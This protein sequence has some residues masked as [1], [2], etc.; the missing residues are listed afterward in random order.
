MSAR[1]RR[2]FSRRI[3]SAPRAD[4]GNRARLLFATGFPGP[5][6]YNG[7]RDRKGGRRRDDGLCGQCLCAQRPD[8]LPAAPVHRAAGGSAPAAGALR[9]GCGAG[10]SLR[11]G[12]V[13]AGV[14]VSQ[15]AAGQGRGGG[16]PGGGGLRR[17][18]AAPPA[19]AAV[20]RRVLRHGRVRVG[21]GTAGGRRCADG[22]GRLL[23]RRLRQGAADRRRGRLPG[24]DGGVPGGGPPRP[25]RAPGA[26]PGVPGGADRRPDGPAGHRQRPAGPGDRRGGAGGVPGRSGRRSAASGAAP[27]DTGAAALPAGPAGT[28]GS[29]GAPAAV[30]ARALPGGGCTGGAA[31]GSAQRLDGDRRR[32]APGAD[33]GIFP[34]GPGAGICRPVGRR[35]RQKESGT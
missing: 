27:S 28:G 4:P 35:D 19:D 14:R 32:A 1:I 34:H 10:R 11:R 20:F 21:P 22:P 23:Y 31:A 9:V 30:A 25:R 17:R 24:A 33:G 3:F 8:G 6:S 29:G 15:P 2:G 13:P 26:G 5:L 7:P 18:S 16:G 12:G